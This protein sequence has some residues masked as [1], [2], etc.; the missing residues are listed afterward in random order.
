VSAVDHVLAQVAHREEIAELER[1][2][3]EIA[4]P[5]RAC[6]VEPRE[7]DPARAARRSPAPAGWRA[8]QGAS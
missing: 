5:P 6:G 4:W 3:P 7:D 8:G 2:E 1:E